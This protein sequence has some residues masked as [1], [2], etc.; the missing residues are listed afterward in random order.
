MHKSVG[1]I[2][3][4]CSGE[5]AGEV[6]EEI[7]S[8]G[9]GEVP[10]LEQWFDLHSA[11]NTHDMKEAV[12][13]VRNAEIAKL[14]RLVANVVVLHAESSSNSDMLENRSDECRNAEWKGLRDERCRRHL[15]VRDT[16]GFDL[17]HIE[18]VL[19]RTTSELLVHRVADSGEQNQT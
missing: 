14:L 19:L 6:E 13:K 8:D 3:D 1:E 7:V 2:P 11:T 18:E 16:T 12:R 5:V 9:V 17:S 4:G 15:R 10:R